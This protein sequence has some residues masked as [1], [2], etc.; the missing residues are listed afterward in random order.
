MF[1]SFCPRYGDIIHFLPASYFFIFL[2]CGATIFL[3][4]LPMAQYFS[5]KKLRRRT[6]SNFCE[7]VRLPSGF[8]ENSRKQ[9]EFGKIIRTP[10][11]LLALCRYLSFFSLGRTR[12][13]LVENTRKRS[14]MFS[15][16]RTFT[17]LFVYR[18]SYSFVVE[19]SR[20]VSFLAE[21]TLTFPKIRQQKNGA[22]K[23]IRNYIL[24]IM[25]STLVPLFL[26]CVDRALLIQP[27]LI[28]GVSACFSIFLTIL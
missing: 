25:I 3:F 10:S 11:D 17:K 23:L 4:S 20:K 14:Y 28:Y 12:S 2:V 16:G 27:A 19:V 8:V 21:N 15:L 13:Y 7:I 26:I 22:V 5:R 1:L 18:R 9:S 24:Y 6:R